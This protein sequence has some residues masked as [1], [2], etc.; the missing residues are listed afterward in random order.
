MNE[1]QHLLVRINGVTGQIVGGVVLQPVQ[2][3][4]VVD[5]HAAGV[6][7]PPP[8][9]VRHPVDPPQTRSVAEMEVSHGV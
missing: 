5:H 7:H 2:V 3:V 9:R 8:G 1:V 6:G 4:P